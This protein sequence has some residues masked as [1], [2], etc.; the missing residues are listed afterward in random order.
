MSD[1]PPPAIAVRAVIAARRRLMA[2]ADRL[3]P[4]HIALFDRS[5]GMGRTHVIGTLAELGVADELAGSPATAE[6]LAGRL[7]VNADALHRVMRAAAL[8]GILKLDRHGVFSL[9]RTGE[10]LRSDHPIPMRDWARY[11]SLRS[12]S[13]AWSDLTETVR[14]GSASFPRIHGSSVWKWFGEHP[15][16]ERLFAGGMRSLTVQDAPFIVQGY[17]WPQDGVICDVAGGV[18]T[19]LGAIL[20]AR[21]GVRGVLVDGPGV[22]AEADGWLTG[23]GLRDRVELSE[24]DIFR[25]LSARADVYLL[26]NI[27]HDWDDRASATILAT[28][29]ATMPEGSRL[30]VVESL[31]ERNVPNVVASLSDIQMMTQC[32]DGRERSAEEIQS[33]LRG[34]GLRPGKVVQ[35]GGPGLVE[36]FA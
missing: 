19:L 13:A 3:V 15:E 21:P 23:R 32:D 25:S 36:A 33:L 6:E 24:G 4:A 9:G 22:L 8:E 1:R 17:P 10:A 31:Q 16:E 20:D 35:T 18:G 28:V 34:A 27:L 11:F 2:L 26:K 14:T 5:V 7:N 12:T 30:V 29:R